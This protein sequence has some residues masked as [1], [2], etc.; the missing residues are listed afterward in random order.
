MTVAIWTRWILALGAFCGTLGQCS[1]AKASTSLLSTGTLE[2][3]LYRY[4]RD[5]QI[6][7][8]RHGSFDGGWRV[9]SKWNGKY[10]A[11]EAN[12]FL[13]SQ[14][15]L[16]LAE[17]DAITPLAKLS[18]VSER[19]NRQLALFLSESQATVEPPGTINYWPI[20]DPQ[21]GRRGL[22]H[23]IAR[24]SPLFNIPNDIDSSSQAFLWFLHENEHPNFLEGFVN[25]VGLYRDL[26]RNQQH[27][28]DD[29]WKRPGSG[30]F[31]TWTEP[32][33]SNDP[34]SRIPLG[35][36]D[37][38]C[39]VNL[40]T[41]SA[42]AEWRKSHPLPAATKSGFDSTC[43]LLVDA[44][45]RE[46]VP[47]CAAW[48]DRASQFWLALARAKSH[49]VRCLDTV[50]PIIREKAETRMNRLITHD[51]EQ[52]NPTEMAEILIAL[53]RLTPSE[54]RSSSLQLRIEKLQE[55]LRRLLH[56][57]DRHAYVKSEDSLFKASGL[58]QRVDWYSPAY[59][60][61]L[62]LWAL[63]EP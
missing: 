33:T 32:E 18:R 56:V 35:V 19:A 15:L 55:V 45:I 9:Y 62:V 11:E 30:A 51:Y 12:S 8:A 22:S 48:Y 52:I 4:I 1:T 31:L 63:V 27:P 36:N 44:V 29:K 43:R 57:N 60:S 41:L 39:V 28:N 21:T 20:I 38:D 58:A 40:N 17:V 7:G 25:T 26:N 2:T 53:K 50:V 6:S 59:S 37:V 14:E 16:V 3:K 42:L 24:V 10:F 54:E 23:P 46:T 5:T 13:T 61:A 47:A 49:G 34:H